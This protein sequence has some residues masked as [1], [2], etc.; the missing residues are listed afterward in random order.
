[1]SKLKLNLLFLVLFFVFTQGMWERILFFLPEVTYIVDIAVV[2]FLLFQFRFSTK[3]PGQ[4]GFLLYLLIAFVIGI[5]NNDS[6]TEIF[7]YTRFVVYTFLIYVQLYQSNLEVQQWQRIFAFTFWL[8]VAQILGALY[9]LLILGEQ[10][11]GFV[12]LM[13]SNGGTTATVFPLLISSLV[14]LYYLFR[15]KMGMKQWLMLGLIFASVFMVA[16]ASGKRGIYF[17]VPAFFIITILLSFRTLFSNGFFQKKLV[18]ISI[19]GVLIFPFLIYGIV[20]S[21]GLNYSLSGNESYSEIIMNSFTFAEEY[22]S[23]TDQY[24]R[25]IGRSNT[26]AQILD[27]SL[28]DEQLFISGAGYGTTKEESTMLRLG[29]GYGIVGFTR[30]IV[31]AGWIYSIMTVVLISG[32]I[33]RNRSYKL[34]ITKVARRLILLI[35]LYT[36]LFY[37]SDLTVSLKINLVIVLLLALINSPVHKQACLQILQQHKL[38]K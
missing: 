26:T 34:G 19:I 36:H 3:T 5:S 27:K 2:G 18:G 9:T 10:V 24:G 7:L 21:R 13:S 14:F 23:A 11:E 37:S 28:G 8:V 29:Y 16:Y 32:I 25:T 4:K 22:E 33:L 30:D 1:M 20:N 15:S 12:G 38:I 31:S 35:F 17:T 6:P